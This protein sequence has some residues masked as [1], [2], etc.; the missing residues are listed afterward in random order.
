M[1]RQT[2]NGEEILMNESQ[3]STPVNSGN[4]F[5]KIEKEHD[6]SLYSTPKSEF[7]RG[8]FSRPLINLVPNSPAHNL[9]VSDY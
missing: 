2:G 3:Y 5:L 6:E 7:K 4:N 1:Y 9:E 8:S